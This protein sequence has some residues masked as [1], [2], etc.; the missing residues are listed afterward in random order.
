MQH[1]HQSFILLLVAVQRTAVKKC[2]NDTQA[3]THHVCASQRPVVSPH[4]GANQNQ[5]VPDIACG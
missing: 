1:A 5:T 4:R 2:S 3:T